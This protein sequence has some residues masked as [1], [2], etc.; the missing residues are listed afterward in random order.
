MKTSKGFSIV[1]LMGMLAVVGTLVSGGVATVSHLSDRASSQKLHSDVKLLNSA[2]QVYQA[3]GGDLSS[4]T[5]VDQ[6]L[7][8][9]RS[10][11]DPEL[12]SLV[13]GMTGSMID[14]RLR[15]VPMSAEEVGS[16][17]ERAIWD[18]DAQ[19]FVVVEGGV[20]GALRFVVGD[21]NEVAPEVDNE[22]S[23][24]L[25]Y[26]NGES[27]WLWDFE[28]RLDDGVQGP[29]VIH[30][31]GNEVADSS[32]AQAGFGGTT[33]PQNVPSLQAPGFSQEGGLFSPNQ[34][35]LQVVLENPNPD[36]VSEVF[37]SVDYGEWE[38]YV[39]PLT[40]QP[41]TVLTAQVV[42]GSDEF[43]DSQTASQT[44]QVEETQLRVP[45]IHASQN[46]GSSG[47]GTVVTIANPN[48]HNRSEVEYRLDGSEWAVYTGVL[49]LNSE[50][51]GEE[52]T[53]SARAVSDRD[54]YLDSELVT[55]VVEVA[56]GN[57]GNSGNGNSSGSE[58]NNGHGNNED[59][60]DVSNPGQGEGGPNGAIDESGEIDDEIGNQGTGN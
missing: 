13:P 18:A 33:M 47:N 34:F 46:S 57:S 45:V 42:A 56:S 4:V 32:P 25:L 19:K 6:V 37:Y 15:S 51:Y 55:Q 30:V 22:R 26:S 29:T 52:V 49:V 60:V 9:L 23:F 10:V 35:D 58:T 20:G 16:K 43:L 24:V 40:V 21:E 3:F 5:T 50:T 48:P 11:T 12:V 28:D 17:V 54:Y 59:G 38:R 53:V 1:E 44:Y 31:A 41:G 39:L 14:R 27:K 8:R 7:A 36:G 2:V